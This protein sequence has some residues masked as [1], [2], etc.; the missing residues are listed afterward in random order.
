MINV[1]IAWYSDLE[2]SSRKREKSNKCVNYEGTK[3]KYKNDY[4]PVYEL[5]M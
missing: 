4:I 3:E 5:L 1:V 2:F